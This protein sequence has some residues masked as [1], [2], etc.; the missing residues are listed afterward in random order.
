MGGE[1][2]TGLGEPE[3]VRALEEPPAPPLAPFPQAGP[4]TGLAGPLLVGLGGPLLLI[5]FSAAWEP[6]LGNFGG[7]LEGESWS[8]VLEACANS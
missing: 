6:V 1:L 7:I 3:R 4:F 5:L 2:L 8:G